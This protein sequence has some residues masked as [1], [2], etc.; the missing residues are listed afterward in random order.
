V[1]DSIQINIKGFD[2]WKQT[3]DFSVS[4]DS[5]AWKV[6]DK[7]DNVTGVFKYYL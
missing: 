2:N 6:I 5:I 1:I 4:S 3:F 7:K